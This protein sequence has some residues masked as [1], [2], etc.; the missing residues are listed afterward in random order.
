MKKRVHYWP[1]GRHAGLAYL[2][3][4]GIILLCGFNL[5]AGGLEQAT[6][7]DAAAPAPLASAHF[8]HLH[9]N[10]TDPAA[11]IAFYTSKFDSEKA[12][13]AGLMDAV[14]AQKSWM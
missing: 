6:P 4:C 13:F 5:T 2:P 7:Q 11:A 9:L 1:V 14:W 12:R 3:L 10:T 8:H